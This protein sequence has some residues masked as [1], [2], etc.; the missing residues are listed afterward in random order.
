MIINLCQK[1]DFRKYLKK[2]F[3]KKNI[4]NSKLMGCIINPEYSKRVY[5]ANTLDSLEDHSKYS[6][7]LY[8]FIKICIIN[9]YKYIV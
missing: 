2:K 3:G 5:K 7:E 6:Y 8:N 9:D 1:T 4:K